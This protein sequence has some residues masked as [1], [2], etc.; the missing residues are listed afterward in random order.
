MMLHLSMHGVREKVTDSSLQQFDELE[1]SLVSLVNSIV[2]QAITDGSLKKQKHML[3]TEIV[4]GMW[5]LSS[6]GQTLQMSDLPLEDFGI[7]DPDMTLLRTLMVVLDGL[8]WQPL[9][10]EA[11]FK[12]LLK[13][14][15]TE[16]FAEEYQQSIDSEHNNP[17][18]V[19]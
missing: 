1:L 2:N 15:K 9:H 11:Q 17:S 10:N 19:T 5:S 16:L 8:S 12:K 18:G 6:G 7:K 14:F 13:R 3:A 4:F